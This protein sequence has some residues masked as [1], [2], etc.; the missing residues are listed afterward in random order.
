M[1][2]KHVLKRKYL[3]LFCLVAPL[4]DINAEGS[5]KD[6]NMIVQQKETMT[7][8]GTV[9]DATGEPIIGVSVL[10]KGTSTGGITDLDGNF[11]IVTPKKRTILVFTYLGY[12]TQEI[13]VEKNTPIF[14]VMEEDSQQLDE[15][16]V[17]G[18]GSQAKI[19]VTGAL[20]SVKNEEI[21]PAP[22][23]N[24]GNALAGRTTGI[25]TVQR[26][27]EPG[28]DDA[29][30]Y[31]R[32]IATFADGN[33]KPLILVDG[34]ERS[35]SGL[36]P[37][38]I[39]SINVM[40]DAS[41][42]AVFGVRGANGVIIV[43]TKTGQ[44][45]RPKISL[46][47][48]VALQ[49]PIRMPKLLNAYEWASLR[50]E[51]AYQDSTDPEQVNYPFSDYD[52]ERYKNGDDPIF[53]PDINWM[54]YMLK[55][56]S[57]QHQH[58][59]SVQGGNK[60]TKY[61]VSLGYYNQQGIYEMGS[62]FKDFSA[63]PKYNRYNVRANLDFN[64]TNDFTI[65][66][67]SGV[68]MTESNYAGSD[69]KTI[70]G[71][72]FSAN[73]VM[74]P[75]TFD[76]KM[77]RNVQGL[78][79]WQIS[80]PPLYEML[81]KGFNENFTA[82]ANIDIAARY[83]LDKLIKGLAVRGKVAYDNY[84]YQKVSRSKQIPMYDIKLD[85]NSSV[86]EPVA[87]IIPNQYEG[88]VKTSSDYYDK[89]R[90]IYGEVAL[91]YNN[92]FD[93]HNVSALFLGTAE[94]TYNG[95]NELPYNYLGLVARATYNYKYR[96]MAEI[97]AGYNG[98]ENFAKGKQFGFFPSFSVGYAFTEDVYFPKNDILSFGKIRASYGL[99]GN[100]RIGGERFLFLPD[101]YIRVSSPGYYFGTGQTKYSGYKE[102]KLGNPYVTWEK[103]KKTNLG[104]DLR[105]FKDRLNFS[106]DYFI[107]KRSNILYS[108][109]LPLWF[110]DPSIVPPYNVGR[111]ENKGYEFEFGYKD[112]INSIGL[113]YWVNGNYSFARNKIIYK[114][115]APKKYPGLYETGSRIG[116]P[117]GLIAEG[118]YNTW[119]EVNDPDRPR[120]KW[121]GNGL[122]PG[123]IK[124]KDITGDNFIDE[125]DKVN[126]GYPNVPEIVYGIS[127]G[128]QW[129]NFSI[130]ALFQGAGHVS[131][132]LSGTAAWPFVA[133]T[134]AAF[135]TA[136]ESWTQERYEQGLPIS[137]PRLSESPEG[138]KHNYQ[139][140]T[141]WQEDASYLRLKNV[142][143]AYLF[144][145]REKS[146]VQNLRLYVN[147]QNLCTWT[148]MSY[149]DPE[150]ADSNGNAYPMMRVFNMGINIQF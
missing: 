135:E 119:E 6:N 1:N 89:N 26:S 150:I 14:I 2:L 73:P 147:G 130:S 98:S 87:I 53:H 31:V 142:E 118:F 28:R 140:S 78:E 104:L 72:I 141:M 40:K 49:N 24:A 3:I 129:K 59:L 66:V 51:A 76:G 126:I 138:T 105:F 46:T 145:F 13:I 86:E 101:A 94:R 123:D 100:D 82:R 21:L 68:Q 116:Q 42:T 97:N 62:F 92:N 74:S 121:E 117:K 144:K 132:Y 27:G 102:S 143:V 109:N 128:F 112:E 50:N 43:T 111:T 34:V 137:L 44:E 134:K 38:E 122:R 139:Y 136:K 16:V 23:A 64:I 99:V 30:I 96:Y 80:N 124:Y 79:K 77:I 95:K 75:V 133:G 29:E 37:N 45:G 61:Y 54:D 90:R 65:S 114:D 36:D 149:F 103:A 17:V 41:S 127:L 84:Y 5:A 63:N 58:N 12:K 83:K 33:A 19:S 10:I 55:N 110:G 7:V 8:T 25:T 20:G 131:T 125:N 91:E 146:P 106:A 48:N 9:K 18:Y 148:K 67:K 56:V 93:G 15:V 115:E 39:E 32:G 113:T 52:L 108:L 107:E 88:P 11:S 35:L 4:I 71:T 81:S 60:R 69:A 120:S 85:P 57:I 22:V 47:S 70:M